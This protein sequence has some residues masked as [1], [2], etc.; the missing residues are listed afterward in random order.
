MTPALIVLGSPGDLEPFPA[1]CSA[2][3]VKADRQGLRSP[4]P[5]PLPGAHLCVESRCSAEQY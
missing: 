5:D 1:L 2:G 4:L 3:A